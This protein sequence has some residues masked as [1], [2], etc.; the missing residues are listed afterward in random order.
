MC[1]WVFQQSVCAGDLVC[2]LDC[3]RACLSV[4]V[5]VFVNPNNVSLNARSR[6]DAIQRRPK[7]VS[8]GFSILFNTGETFITAIENNDLV[9]NP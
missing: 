1:L 9:T 7:S 8:F 3:T 6:A 2:M 4:C 5:C